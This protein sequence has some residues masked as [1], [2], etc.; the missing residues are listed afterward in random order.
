MCVRARCV[1][2]C[3]CVYVCVCVLWHTARQRCKFLRCGLLD[4]AFFVCADV[5]I[6]L[7]LIFL[8]QS[9]ELRCES[10]WSVQKRGRRVVDVLSVGGVVCM[11]DVVGA[12]APDTSL[13][14]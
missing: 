9:S 10:G 12:S 14:S 3:V 7:C 4:L 13:E 6:T 2:V 1:C 8:P 5:P 11:C